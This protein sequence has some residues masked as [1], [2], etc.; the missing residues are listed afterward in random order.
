MATHSSILAW[1]IPWTEESGSLQSMGSQRVGHNWTN[2]TLVV[3]VVRALNKALSLLTL[4]WLPISICVKKKKK[5]WGPGRPLW[6]APASSPSHLLGFSAASSALGTLPFLS[7]L[8]GARQ[9]FASEPLCSLCLEHPSIV[10]P[11]RLP[12]FLQP[13]LQGHLLRYSPVT[14][15]LSFFT[16][17]PLATLPG[18]LFSSSSPGHSFTYLFRLCWVFVTA[19]A[20]L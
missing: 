19:R 13:L 16:L 9:V 11:S 3:H 4:L 6:G 5:A 8:E 17:F 12:R 20:F 10:A 7:F 18:M 2:I 1:R 15:D 14:E